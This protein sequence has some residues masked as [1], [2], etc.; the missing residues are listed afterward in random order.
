MPDPE[1]AEALRTLARNGIFPVDDLR[2]FIKKL[3]KDLIK[4]QGRSWGIAQYTCKVC[5]K[6][7]IAPNTAEDIKHDSNCPYNHI[8]VFEEKFN[9]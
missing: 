6:M 5:R 2:Q 7:R 9:A 3:K 1:V 4:V 8:L